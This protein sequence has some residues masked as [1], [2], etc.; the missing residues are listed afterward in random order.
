MVQVHVAESKDTV[1]ALAGAFVAEASAKAIAASGRF[2]V[3]ISGGSLPKLLASGIVDDK[4]VEFSKWHVFLPM[5]GSFRWITRTATTLVAMKSCFLKWGFQREQIYTLDASLAPD[6]CAAAY[7]K[8]LLSICGGEKPVFDL[9][10]L[11]MGPDGHTASL[12]PGHNLLNENE[13]W[14]ASIVDS[15]KPP[16][17]R[18]T[19]TL[20]TIRLSKA[21]CICCRRRWKSRHYRRGTVGRNN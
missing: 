13:K 18:I 3:A 2:I 20:P 12:F 17:K 16:P 4:S 8:N 10:L 21:D 1:G 5:K 7:E 15:P 6:D 9:I 19:L 11:G 14:V